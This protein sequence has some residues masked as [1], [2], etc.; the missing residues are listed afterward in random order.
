MA[1]KRS[2]NLSLDGALIDAAKAAGLNI[3]IFLEQQLREKMRRVLDEQ[4]NR[5]NADAI[6]QRN[7]YT[8]KHGLWCDEFRT[9]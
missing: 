3:S 9:W 7:E 8:E 1:A 2:L 5:D 4:W 6:R